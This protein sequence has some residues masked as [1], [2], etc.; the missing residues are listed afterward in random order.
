MIHR[1]NK[2]MIL[3]SC[4]MM[5]VMPSCSSDDDN[6]SNNGTEPEQPKGMTVE[7][8]K[9]KLD[10]VAKLMRDNFK[11]EEIN[12]ATNLLAHALNNYF[13][14]DG[15]NLEAL[16]AKYNIGLYNCSDPTLGNFGGYF[17]QLPM[18]NGKL[19]ATKEGWEVTG[20][21]DALELS[22]PDENGVQC[23]FM[24]KGSKD[25]YRYDNKSEFNGMPCVYAIPKQ[26]EGTLTRGGTQV[27]TMIINPVMKSE[28][29]QG[30]IF[31]N[32][33]TGTM[34]WRS[35][36]YDIIIEKKDASGSQGCEINTTLKQGALNAIRSALTTE[37]QLFAYDTTVADS[38]VVAPNNPAKLHIDVLAK[39][40]ADGTISDLKTFT[41]YLNDASQNDTNEQ[42]FKAALE[43]A[44]GC[45]NIGVYYDGSDERMANVILMAV[46]ER[47][48][49]TGKEVWD[50]QP[51]ISFS[52]GT[53][54]MFTNIFGNIS[55]D[56]IKDAI[57]NCNKR[58]EKMKNEYISARR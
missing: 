46:A 41:D 1:I 40:V 52:D 47:D 27:A 51:V 14:A 53:S 11:T 42:A 49:T 57:A 54:Y 34:K 28:G 5:M 43:K 17:L 50:A 36:S 9:A 48:Q 18:F 8:Q 3:L 23:T 30:A 55:F 10:N 58:I 19:A 21:S 38:I 32:D 33:V 45:L 7:E 6:N 35:T 39:V 44:N 29:G 24:I 56:N 2:C 25:Y 4:A 26:A 22:F 31:G 13:A 37:K 16:D 15:Y 20:E 12:D